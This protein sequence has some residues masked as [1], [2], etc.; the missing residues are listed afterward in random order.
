VGWIG[1][2]L[3]LASPIIFGLYGWLTSNE[4][5]YTIGVLLDLKGSRGGYQPVYKYE[6]LGEEIQLK[7]GSKGMID[8]K[9]RHKYIGKRYYVMVDEVKK[10]RSRIL[11]DYP[12]PDSIKVVPPNGWDSIPGVGELENPFIWWASKSP[13]VKKK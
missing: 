6:I 7:S 3:F 10:N 8:A 2:I 11:L 12:V 1:L 9:D 5:R 13:P 4:Q